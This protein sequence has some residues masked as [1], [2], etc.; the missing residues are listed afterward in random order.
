MSLSLQELVLGGPL[1]EGL[2]VWVLGSHLSIF[3]A[4]EHLQCHKG[5]S[6]LTKRSMMSLPEIV[7]MLVI[8]MNGVCCSLEEVVPETSCS[9]VA[10]FLST[11]SGN[12]EDRREE[13]QADTREHSKNRDC[14]DNRF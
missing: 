11:L 5:I 12:P 10:D 13:L 7:S 2:W 8:T 1:W 3:S 6:S 4:H 14:R 9:A